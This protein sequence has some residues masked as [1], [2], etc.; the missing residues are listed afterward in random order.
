M[1]EWPHITFTLVRRPDRRQQADRR[2]SWRGGRRA[3]DMVAK[4]L[5]GAAGAATVLWRLVDGMLKGASITRSLDDVDQSLRASKL[6]ADHDLSTGAFIALTN[7]STYAQK[8][9]DIHQLHRILEAEL[10]CTAQFYL[11]NRQSGF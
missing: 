6:P 8:M 5:Q 4:D 11:Q 2:N 7:A 1:T 3:S 9:P 10:I